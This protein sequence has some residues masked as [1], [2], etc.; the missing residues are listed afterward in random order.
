MKRILLYLAAGSGDLI[1]FTGILA[2]LHKMHMTY[3]FDLLIN[4][5]HSYIVDGHPG[6]SHL[7]YLDKFPRIPDH[8]TKQGHDPIVQRTFKKQYDGIYNCWGCKTS[9]E[10][11]GDFI[12]MMSSLMREYGFTLPYQRDELNPIFYYDHHD[13]HIVDKITGTPSKRI[14]LVEAEAF[15]WQSPQLS[16]LPQIIHYLKRS[17]Y[18]VAGN[19]LS[20]P[21]TINVRRLNLKQLKLFFEKY[22]CGFLGIS[23]GMSCAVYAEPNHYKDKIVAVSGIFP[24][25]DVGEHLEARYYSTY[26]Y[27]PS[28]FTLD[29]VRIMFKGG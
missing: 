4:R 3:E 26:L 21:D 28:V 8:C 27:F 16:S 25:W 1:N 5:K 11:T 12:A 17:G 18:I 9:S 14:V 22:C 23:S 29:D 6:I 15:S 13:Y 2:K 10:Q 19:D 24:H 7:L 20:G